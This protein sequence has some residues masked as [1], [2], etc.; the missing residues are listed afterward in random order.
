[1]RKMRW[2][3]LMVMALVLMLAVPASAITYGEPDEGQHPYVGLLG[4]YDAEGEWMWR[5]SG[6]M[7]SPTVVLTAGHCTGYDPEY[8]TPA[9]AQIWFDEQVLIDEENGYPYYGGTMGTPYPHPNYVGL[10]IPATY[11]IGVVVLDEPVSM[12]RYA[13]LPEAGMLDELA[14]RRG[15]AERVFTVVGY[16]LNDVRPETISLRIRYKAL[17]NLVS[18]QSAITDGYNLQ[19]S[20]NPGQWT[21]EG[22]SG[23]TCFGDS[24][25]PVFYGGYDS[26]LVVAITSFGMNS[27]CSGTDFAYRVD[28][29]DSLGFLAPFLP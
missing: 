4:F 16:G 13:E 29:E 17:S 6:T 5:C 18:L 11:D 14:T 19:T 10:Y 24:G 7:I 25:G 21:D 15:H 8:G 27:N 22:I 23:G 20:N 12:P 28:T 26:D 2:V 1:M 9:R 3:L